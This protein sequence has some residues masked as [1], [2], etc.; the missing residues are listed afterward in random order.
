LNRT[1]EDLRLHLDEVIRESNRA[2]QQGCLPADSP[3]RRVTNGFKAV[4]YAAY[5]E[6]GSWQADAA[7]WIAGTEAAYGT[8]SPVASHWS[9]SDVT[10]LVRDEREAV[11]SYRITLHY[12]DEKK[13]ERHALFLE[14]YVRD[15]EGW[16]LKRHT[17]E[18]DGASKQQ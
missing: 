1:E 2:L 14:T 4:Q 12:R 11:A 9:I 10:V 7:S 8:L 6:E 16:A 18:K 3:L 13:P 5:F 15:E 17:A